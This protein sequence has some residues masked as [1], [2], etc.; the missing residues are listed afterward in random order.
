MLEQLTRGLRGRK[1]RVSIQF[2][3]SFYDLLRGSDK[4]VF[5]LTFTVG[6]KTFLYTFVA[7]Y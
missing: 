7:I 6:G 1:Q 3:I 5:Q 4:R 2:V